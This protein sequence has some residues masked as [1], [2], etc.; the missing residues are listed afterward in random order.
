MK[1]LLKDPSSSD[2][3]HAI[4]SFSLI[5]QAKLSSDLD[6]TVSSMAADASTISVIVSSVWNRRAEGS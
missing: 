4:E 6:R 2:S 5:L 1:N 3:Y